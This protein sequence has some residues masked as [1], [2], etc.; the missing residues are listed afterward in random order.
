MIDF[1]VEESKYLAMN[2]SPK[3]A[4]VNALSKKVEKGILLM[5]ASSSRAR[6]AEVCS[7]LTARI[8]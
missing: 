3:V 8:L 4:L 2:E 5:K 6:F 7:T 1:P